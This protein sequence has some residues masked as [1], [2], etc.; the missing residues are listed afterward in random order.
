MGVFPDDSGTSKSRIEK[1]STPTGEAARKTA[2]TLSQFG[3]RII[4]MKTRARVTMDGG[5]SILV[6]ESE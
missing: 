1:R 3:R 6:V 4:L 5:A 2:L